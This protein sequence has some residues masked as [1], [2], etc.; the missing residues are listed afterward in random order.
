MKLKAKVWESYR[1]SRHG[2]AEVVIDL[3]VGCLLHSL[4]Y[5]LIGMILVEDK[6]GFLT[7]ITLGTLAAVC[8]CIDM[9]RSVEDTVDRDPAKAGRY[10]VFRSIL[11]MLVMLAVLWIAIRSRRISLPGTVIGLMGLKVSAYLHMYVNVYITGRL[12]KKGR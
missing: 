2:S 9:R 5:A 12:R 4:L 11:R 8:L 10:M 1:G 3:I 7:G 6:A